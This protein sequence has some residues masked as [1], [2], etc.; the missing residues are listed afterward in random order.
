MTDK[1][2]LKIV[3]RLA[4]ED[5]VAYYKKYCLNDAPLYKKLNSCYDII[6][7]SSSF[8]DLEK[9]KKVFSDLITKEDNSVI[10]GC[11]QN[12]I[13]YIDHPVRREKIEAFPELETETKSDVRKELE[14]LN[15]KIDEL[16]DV[17]PSLVTEEDRRDNNLAL[18]ALLR[19]RKTLIESNFHVDGTFVWKIESLEKKLSKTTKSGMENDSVMNVNKFISTLREIIENYSLFKTKSEK[20]KLLSKYNSMILSLFHSLDVEISMS[21]NPEDVV[22][23]RDLIN[24]AGIYNLDGNYN[25]F[26]N[27]YKNHKIASDS[28]SKDVYLSNVN[29][30]KHIINNLCG[31][32]HAEI[33]KNGNSVTVSDYSDTREGITREINDMYKEMYQNEEAHYVHR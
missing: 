17:R 2:K 1:E 4:Y 29:Y 27:K 3:K 32:C 15:I 14:D 25:E 9:V 13:Y 26:V 22:T 12:F 19:K 10:I 21:D 7:K 28:I 24:Y 8:A 33:M 5:V 30:I 23:P 18:A 20:D 6:R 11:L 31:M 16:Y